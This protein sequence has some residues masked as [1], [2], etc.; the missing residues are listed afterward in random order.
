LLP[1]DIEKDAERYLLTHQR[2][3][4]N[5]NIVVAP[6]HGSRTSSTKGLVDNIN[7]NYVIYT[8]GYRNRYGFPK[9]QVAKRYQDIG[10]QAYRSDDSGALHF[11]LDGDGDIAE[12]RQYRL[13][14]R[15]FWHT[16]R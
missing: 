8:V 12:P 9:E 15:R 14:Q 6:H 10:A 7:P 1:G 4:L 16:V 2:D 11:V 5:A 3:K 13:E